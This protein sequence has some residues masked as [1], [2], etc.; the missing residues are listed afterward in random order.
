MHASHVEYEPERSG[1][2][3]RKCNEDVCTAH[4]GTVT[5]IK[6]LYALLT[7]LIG[8]VG[9]QMMFQIPAIRM[10]ILGEVN[11]I[12]A[13]IVELE[14]KDIDFAGRLKACEDVLNNL[15]KKK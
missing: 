14:K 4:S 12:T 13:R 5:G 10:D 15:E 1:I 11:K 3:R 8:L 9:G 2:D 7:I 6:G